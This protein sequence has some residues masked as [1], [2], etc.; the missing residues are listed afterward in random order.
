MA[1]LAAL[2]RERKPE[3]EL[4]AHF[5]LTLRTLQRCKHDIKAFTYSKCT[6][7]ELDHMVVR[8]CIFLRYEQTSPEMT[9]TTCLPAPD[10]SCGPHG[11]ARWA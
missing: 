2:V 1:E 4:A 7:E 8:L 9:K 5:G 10:G 6:D 11:A 3:K